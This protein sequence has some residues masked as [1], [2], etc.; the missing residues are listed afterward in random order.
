M[1]KT[2]RNSA[3]NSTKLSEE[4]ST[5]HTNKLLTI[6]QLRSIFATY[7]KQYNNI[8]IWQ[9]SQTPVTV[10]FQKRCARFPTNHS[11]HII[12]QTESR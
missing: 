5:N 1:K 10:I 11:I 8:A 6:K 2:P 12:N 9:Y 7:A 4:K 3:Q